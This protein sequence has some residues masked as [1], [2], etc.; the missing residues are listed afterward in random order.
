LD[1]AIYSGSF[2]AGL[3]QKASGSFTDI[4][5]SFFSI[6]GT[7]SLLMNLVGS[8]NE[9]GGGENQILYIPAPL[10]VDGGSNSVVVASG[11]QQP[12][13]VTNNALSRKGSIIFASKSSDYLIINQRELK[14]DAETTRLVEGR[15][16]DYF[17]ANDGKLTYFEKSGSD[18][19][20]TYVLKGTDAAKR[21]VISDGYFIFEFPIGDAKS[22]LERV[23][24]KF[25]SRAAQIDDDLEACNL[26]GDTVIKVGDSSVMNL[27]RTSEN[28]GSYSWEQFCV[29]NASAGDATY[30]STRHL[31]SLDP[32]KGMWIRLRCWDKDTDSSFLID[33]RAEFSF[34]GSGPYGSIYNQSSN[35]SYSTCEIA[36]NQNHNYYS[37]NSN[38]G[39]MEVSVSFSSEGGE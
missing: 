18:R 11:D 39:A 21:E 31:S 13:I 14:K 37:S 29:Q 27:A 36:D 19:Y 26:N 7:E 5:G 34:G 30:V 25:S 15:L 38:G 12:Y 32:G 23:T 10:T 8:D 4:Y 35:G 6:L 24:W 28:F 9:D 22:Q 33:D 17:E 1:N 16:T 20:T 2:E 3:E